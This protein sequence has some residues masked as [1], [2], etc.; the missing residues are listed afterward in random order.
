[1]ADLIPDVLEGKVNV[2]VANATCN[3]TGKLIKMV[4]LELKYGVG[5]Y[6]KRAGREVPTLQLVS[7]DD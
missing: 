5:D 2:N 4:E 7:G 3:A 6:P 1:M